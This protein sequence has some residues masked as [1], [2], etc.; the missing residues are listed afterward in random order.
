VNR[1]GLAIG[2]AALVLIVAVLWIWLGSAASGSIAA[3]A[4]RA[5]E[6]RAASVIVQ[7]PELKPFAQ[8][9]SALGTVRAN[10]SVDVTSKV[11]DRVTAI[12]FKEGQQVRKGDLLVELDNAEARADLAAAEAA[13]AESRSQYKRSQELYETRALSEAQLDQI[14][15]TL[16]A[17]ESRVAAARS[18]LDDRLIR[19]PFSG[20]VGLRNVSVGGLV[21]PGE[22]ITTLDDLSIVKLDFALP[23][24]FLAALEPELPVTASSTAYPGETFAGRVAS[25][26]TRVDPTTRSVTIRASIDNSEYRLRPGMFMTIKVVRAERE[27]LIVPERAIVPE[28]T[29]H[30]VFVVEEGVARK[31]EV[32]VGRRRPGE[33][34]ILEGVIP[35]DQ[36]IVDGTL[37][38]REGQP[39]RQAEL[40]ETSSPDIPT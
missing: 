15:A 18:R 3:P 34:E 7:Q 22:V 35:S 39:V 19:A 4:D 17:N 16:L 20:R 12:R 37:G 30:Y 26:G 10:E 25:V 5:R 28:D 6:V 1:R 14:K 29:R 8:E 9:V 11:S 33:V 21:S 24:I 36:V 32:V 38:V 27:A 31:R 13:L 40:A 23:E 2:V